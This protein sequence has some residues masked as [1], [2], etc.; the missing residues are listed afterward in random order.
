MDYGLFMATTSFEWFIDEYCYFRGAIYLRGWAFHPQHAVREFG[1]QLPG[2]IYKCLQGYGQ[3]SGDVVAH[4]G[5]N[6]AQYCRFLT[7]IP[8]ANPNLALQ[9]QLV[10]VLENHITVVIQNITEKA[11]QTDAY[12]ALSRNFFRQLQQFTEGT[13]AELGARARS[14]LSRRD[15]VPGHLK[16]IGMDILDGD[17]VDVV[18]DA[19]DLSHLFPSNSIDAIFS[20]SVFEHLLMPWKVALEMN[21]VLKMG[22]LV[23][24]STHQTW[25][26]HD[27]P[28]DFWRFSDR[29][30][31]GLFN[32]FTGFEIIDTALGLPASIVAHHLSAPTLHL[33]S[34]LAYL[35][36][37]V[38]CRKIHETSLSWAVDIAKLTQDI[39]PA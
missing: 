13:V 9:M 8:L 21:H 7:A 5:S 36:S 29:A 18:G 32:E 10:F 30:W 2:Q 14:G 31:H 16:Y 34:Q 27:A 25:A 35:G 19:H 12:H 15:I 17:N 39:Y 1:Y 4:F 6:T 33:E 3:E 28:W 11:V 23:M 22:G 26:I 37:S 20:I 38:L 24:I